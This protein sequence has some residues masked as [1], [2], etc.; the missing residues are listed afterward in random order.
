M[1][2]VQQLLQKLHHSDPRER[3]RA[4]GLLGKNGGEGVMEPLCRALSDTAW[5]VRWKA[6]QILGS[7]GNAQAVGPLCRALRDADCPII[8]RRAAEALGKI[9]A[10]AA[11]SLCEALEDR[12][13]KVREQAA[14]VLG[15]IGCRGALPALRKRLRLLWGE[16]DAWVRAAMLAAVQRIEE[17]TAATAT[18][19]VPAERPGPS[20]DA[21][22]VPAGTPPPDASRLPRPVDGNQRNPEAQ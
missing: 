13:P 22:P 15:R 16:Q 18:L 1:D 5:E 8:R 7:I 21:L 14:E 6:A 2:E 11:P 9:G 3:R 17:G 20:L 12:M 19:P 4:V 10:P